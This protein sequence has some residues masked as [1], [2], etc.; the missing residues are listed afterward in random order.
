MSRDLYSEEQS[1]M[2]LGTLEFDYMIGNFARSTHNGQC[3]FGLA[4]NHR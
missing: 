2:D 3:E 4:T 1:D